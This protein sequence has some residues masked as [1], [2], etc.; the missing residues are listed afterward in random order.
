MRVIAGKYKGRKLFSPKS[1]NIRPTEDRIKEAIFSIVND[2]INGSICLDLFSGSGQIA[3]E[4]FSR[5]AKFVYLNDLSQDHLD[6]IYENIKLVGEE[7]N[8]KIS[9]KDY[10]KAIKSFKEESL[11]IIYLDPPFDFNY[12]HNVIKI[13][14]DC[15]I[16]KK[17]GIIILE[18]NLKIMPEFNS[19][20]ATIHKT[21]SDINIYIFERFV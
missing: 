1:N 5:G 16:L 3:I 4:L 21:Y 18:T 11:D 15:K 14:E 8:S 7:K 17:G 12:E 6:T 13:I 10:P 20:K 2:K 9:R 19:L